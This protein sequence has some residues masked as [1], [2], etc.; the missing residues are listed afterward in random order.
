MLGCCSAAVQDQCF[1]L[2]RDAVRLTIPAHHCLNCLNWPLLPSSLLHR[3]SRFLLPSYFPLVL[4]AVASLEG[5][6]LSVDKNFK[7]ISAGGWAGWRSRA[8]CCVA[9]WLVRQHGWHGGHWL[10]TELES[11]S[12]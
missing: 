7:L 2:L 10:L 9:Q 5:V 3:P 1:T 4:R 11:A 8:G 6:A 12:G